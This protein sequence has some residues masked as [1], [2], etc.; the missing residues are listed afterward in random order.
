MI[1]MSFLLQARSLFS[2]SSRG[3]AAV[4]VCLTPLAA[5]AQMDAG[6]LRILVLDQ[7]AAV[8][9]GATVT[10]TN[11]N[12]G[13]P[14]NA[15]T[16]AEGYVSFTPLPRGSYDLLAALEGFRSH[17]V[18]SVTV[19]VNERKF[20]RVVLDPASV[21]EAVEVTAG[22]RTLQTEEG[23]LGQVIQGAVAVE[24]PLAG[25]RYTELAL[26][27]P[28]AT[29]STMTLDTRGPGWFLVN[30]NTQT[31]N[32]FMLD[33]F[34]NNQGTQNAQAL[35]SQVV[36]P[37]PD[38]IEQFK[39]QTNSF[40]AEFGRSAGAVVN[41]SIK[42]GTNAIHGSSWYYNRDAS[43]AA[44]SW[45]ANTNG[46]GKDDL[47]WHQA[48]ATFGGPI[49]KNKLFYFGSYEG[50]RRS[51]SQSGVISVPTDA[52]HA[53]AFSVRVV[54]PLTG[55]PFANNTI[56]R[57]R[58]DP[59]AAKIID[60]YSR[61]NRPGRVTSSGLVADNYAY[62]APGEEKTHKVDVRSDFVA[63]ANDRFFVRYSLLQQ[64][65]FREQILEG[66]VE[67]AGNQGEQYNRNHS[68]GA[69]W[70]RIF[71]GRLVNELR[72]GYTNT[73]ARF[74]HATATGITADEFG[75]RGLPPELL[76]TGGIPLLNLTNYQS[77]GIRNFRPQFQRP[78]HYQVL[79]TVT[80][81][82]GRH[83]VRAGFE[84]RLKRNFARDTERVS[85]AYTFNGNFTGNSIADLLLGYAN[86]L[87]ASTVPSVDWRQEAFSGFVQDDYKVSRNLTVNLGLR[88]EYTT[89]YYGAGQFRNTNFDTATGQLIYATDDDKY[90]V[91]PDRN[92]VAPRLGVAYQ[93]IPD[94]LVLRGGYGVF[95]SLEEMNGSE[96][97]IV[98]NPP[99]TINATLTSTGTG[100]SATPAVRLSDPFPAGMLTSYNS[101]TVGVKARQRDQPAAMIQQWNVAAEMPLP[102]ESSVEVAYVGNR[103]DQ[104][105][106]N[107]PINAVQ[108]GQNGAIAANRP[109]PNWQQ[110]S[111]WFSAGRSTFDSL[112]VKFEKRQS[113]GLYVLASYT[114]ANAQEEVGA[115]GAGGHGIQDTLA[116][117]FSNLDAMLRADRGPNTQTARH[118]V[119]L[120]QIWQV[121]VG[122]G[123]AFGGDMSPALD[124]VVGGW[125]LSS[126]TS[127]RTGLPVNVS[128]SRTGTDPA[129]GLAYAFF[130]RNGGSFRP[131]ATGV[132]PNGHS[133]PSADR[134]HFL[135]A[136]AYAVPPLNTPGNAEPAG[137]FG[138][139][140]WTTDISLVKRF[141][142]ARY[143]ADVRAEAF[144]LF[145]HTNYAN[146]SST[147]FP[148]STFGAITS[149]GD[150]RVVQLAV[151]LGF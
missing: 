31:Q 8:V 79:D 59:L 107:L 81:L 23:S 114:F 36:Q 38:A 82:F 5:Y 108:F 21:A 77:V 55:Q 149:A 96:G 50:F 140:A 129:T 76:T 118:R 74:A 46:L 32:N 37:N 142:F 88:Y 144:N 136:A 48:G 15:V 89:P 7:S 64:R 105:Q 65:I 97:M 121:P 150:P 10:L 29:P 123:R 115:W 19:D 131:N 116:R 113:R 66:I 151:R 24:L 62:Q 109:Y 145:N 70:N 143:T 53:G 40:S 85:P 30:G 12:T 26:L 67:Q 69:S 124:A 34:D 63:S 13:V 138:P 110:V 103:G 56:P 4:L 49:A 125:Q 14:Q 58:W 16:D 41:V 45:N 132:D 119:T 80:M 54:D 6:A 134:L 28:G 83:A 120:T 102:W 112:Q 90:L 1:A 57:D 17:Q 98:F 47:K 94:R 130:D 9:P 22:R 11:V 133:D 52:E 146:P 75:F 128:L 87:S 135:D 27:V 72:L 71:G 86:N 104:L 42:S 92:N 25:R 20:L 35:S 43:L 99:T 122:R 111:M 3:L 117:D 148:S 73:D 126:I 106:V 44:K 18:K 127:V 39:V 68:V 78:K 61:P 51:F 147:T 100:P 139:G 141:T 60:A 93:A 137:A 91:D 33:G 84:A 101:S 95:Y 2:S